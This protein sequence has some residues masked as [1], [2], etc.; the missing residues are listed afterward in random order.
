MKLNLEL[1]L[2]YYIH[3]AGYWYHLDYKIHGMLPGCVYAVTASYDEPPT[4]TPSHGP[5]LF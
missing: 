4:W 5:K 1:Q 2:W 3:D